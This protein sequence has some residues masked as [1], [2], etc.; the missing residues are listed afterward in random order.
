ML[1]DNWKNSE[2]PLLPSDAEMEMVTTDFVTVCRFLFRS[3]APLGAHSHINEQITIVLEGEME[4]EFNEEKRLMKSGDV[5]VIPANAVHKA[6]ITK[7][8]FRSIEVF[9]PARKDF[10]A[11]VKP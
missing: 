1:I 11:A 8:P 9:D 5:C 4:I 2:N 6:D 3:P 10:A 7:A